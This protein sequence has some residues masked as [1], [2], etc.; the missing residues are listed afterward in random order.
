ML[1]RQYDDALFKG[2][3]ILPKTAFPDEFYATRQP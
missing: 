1:E 2:P 3:A